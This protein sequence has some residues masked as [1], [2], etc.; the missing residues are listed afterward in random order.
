[1]DHTTFHAFDLTFK[2]KVQWDDDL[3]PEFTEL[4]CE[5]FGALN[6]ASFM[7]ES[8]TLGATLTAAFEE[9]AWKELRS[10]NG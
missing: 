4:W 7:L 1:M 5:A 10:T 3:C 8:P 6:D 2:A 9:V